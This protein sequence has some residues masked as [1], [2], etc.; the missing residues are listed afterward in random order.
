ML[1]TG[2]MAQVRQEFG[3]GKRPVIRSLATGCHCC[4]PKGSLQGTYVTVKIVAGGSNFAGNI[5]HS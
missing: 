3:S 4:L 1:A 5:P 2:E